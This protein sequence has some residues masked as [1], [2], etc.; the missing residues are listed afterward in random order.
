MSVRFAVLFVLP[1]CAFSARER[2]VPDGTLADTPVTSRDAASIDA[3]PPFCDATDTT[4]IACYA[5]EGTTTDGSPNHLDAASAGVTFVPGVVG[6]SA[7]AS[8]QTQMTVA[9]NPLIDPAN[10]TIEAWINAP[11]PATGARAGII[12]NEG[13][14]GFFL[15]EQGELQCITASNVTAN[16]PANTWTH[17]A[18]TYDGANRKIYVNG[19]VVDTTALTGSLAAGV[20][21]M[22]LGA[23]SPSGNQLGGDLDQLRVFSAARTDAQIAADAQR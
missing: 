14:W 10:L 11:L 3:P 21:G 19:V 12:D 20:Q 6:M 5:F 2:S 17:V 18:C 23:N 16:V 1:A 7:V 9:Q 22:A 15:H 13:A 8:A 4:L